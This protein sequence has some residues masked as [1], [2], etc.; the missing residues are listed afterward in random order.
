MPAMWFP[1]RFDEFPRLKDI[2]HFLLAMLVIAVFFH[3]AYAQAPRVT[4]PAGLFIGVD[5]GTTEKFLGIGYAASPDAEHRWRAAAPLP[6]AVSLFKADL[7]HEG[8]AAL[9]SGDAFE[10][11]N[12]N[13]LFLNVYRPRNT[14]AD[15]RLPVIVFIH[16]GGN[17]SG[18]PEIY[19]G[20]AFAEARHAIVVIPAYR[21]GVFGFLALPRTGDGLAPSGDIGLGDL[22]D[23]LRWVHVNIA[24]FGGDVGNVT[25]DG[26]SAGAANVCD[27]LVTPE[28]A[29]LFRQAIMQSGFCP[30][31]YSLSVSEAIGMAT[32]QEAGCAGANVLACLRAVPTATL[33]RSWDKVWAKPTVRLANGQVVPRPLFPVTPSGAALQPVSVDKALKQGDWHRV[34]VLIGFNRDELRGF[35][36]GYFP[37]SPKDYKAALTRAYPAFRRELEALYSEVGN[38]P[39]YNFA[40]MRSD[41]I[42]ICPALRAATMLSASTRVSVYEF[43][44]R[45]APPFHSFALSLPVPPNFQNGAAHTA[46]LPYLFGY[47]SIS[48]PLSAEQ[49]ALSRQMIELWLA[50]GHSDSTWPEWTPDHQIALVISDRAS[51][52]I[53]QSL[54]VAKQHHCDFWDRHPETV[55]TFFP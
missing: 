47:Q 23:A 38:T 34:P 49:V 5:Y 35:L 6:K 31:R 32:A 51:G 15:A 42:L 45:T 14:P 37:M 46:E 50:F 19:D 54:D 16:G 1:V 24:S 12:E 33:L 53:V 52:G 10:T 55:N 13:C 41:Q 8:C 22:L 26:E 7:K 2:I 20:S 48:R 18:T 27:L 11:H 43:A 9:I 29:G 3:T 25:L 36:T 4:A 21:L 40:A 39:F 30:S 28:S 44:D 17:Q